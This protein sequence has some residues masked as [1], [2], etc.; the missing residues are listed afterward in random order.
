MGVAH[1]WVCVPQ[2]RI[3]VFEGDLEREAMAMVQG[4]ARE[5][6]LI[7]NEQVRV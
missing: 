3:V 5:P 2:G 6:V 4:L 7:M 1:R